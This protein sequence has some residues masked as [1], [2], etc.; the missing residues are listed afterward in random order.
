M[1]PNSQQDDSNFTQAWEAPT[2]IKIDLESTESGLDAVIESS[3]GVFS[4]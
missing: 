3:N 4:S 2:L 1:E